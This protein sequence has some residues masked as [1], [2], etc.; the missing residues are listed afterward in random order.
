[1]YFLLDLI[2]EDKIPPDFKDRLEKGKEEATSLFLIIGGAKKPLTRKPIGTWILI[3]R[4]EVKK[5]NSYYLI[6]EVSPELKQAPKGRYV[7][8]IA[9]LVDLKKPLNK[10]KLVK[11]IID[12][13]SNIFQEFNFEKDWDWK[14][15]VLFPIVDGIGRTID[16]YWEKRIGSETPIENLYVAGDSAQEL[17]SGVDG[18]ASSA[19]FACE[20]IT[21]EK[22]IDLNK[23]YQI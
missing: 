3:P 16:W 2:E 21:G 7:L 8:S 14:T 5:V 18:C 11:D 1:M 15:A 20:K 23:F 19:I 10:E 17:S 6:Y 12:D 9:I 4:S 13:M 22:L